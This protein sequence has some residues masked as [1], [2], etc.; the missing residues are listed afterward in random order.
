MHTPYHYL[1]KHLK[2]HSEGYKKLILRTYIVVLR[3]IFLNALHHLFLGIFYSLI[4]NKPKKHQQFLA[5]AEKWGKHVVKMTRT[6]IHHS[7]D[8]QIPPSGHM[9]FLNHINEVDFPFDSTVIQKPYLANQAIKSTILAYWWMSAMGSQVFDTSHARTIATSVRNLMKGLKDQSYIVYPEGHNSYSEEIKPLKKGMIKL[10]FD[11][12]V[13]VVVLVKTGI[14]AFQ[15]VQSDNI[16]G[17]R[18]GGI[19]SPNGF[20][21]WE[22]FRDKIH[23]TMVEEKKILDDEIQK[24][25]NS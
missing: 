24:L 23:L 11:E 9:V 8:L 1:T 13:P 15:D 20:Q 5:G 17:Y 25:K 19:L 4:G 18:F 2:G 22:D 3:V 16:V 12:K 10:A 14:R 21:T 7:N 6:K